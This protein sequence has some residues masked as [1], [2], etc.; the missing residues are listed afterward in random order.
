MWALQ[1]CVPVC[2]PVCV[3]GRK[4]TPWQNA[5]QGNHNGNFFWKWK[6]S[7]AE[8]RSMHRMWAVTLHTC[9]RGRQ[10]TNPTQAR[11]QAQAQE[12]S[13]KKCK[14]KTPNGVSSSSSSYCCPLPSLPPSTLLAVALYAVNNKAHALRMRKTAHSCNRRKQHWLMAASFANSP[15]RP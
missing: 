15:L 13:A 10:S 9:Q 3:W 7:A 1:V 5:V 8:S 11:A 6:I 4:L 14:R 2:L 12:V